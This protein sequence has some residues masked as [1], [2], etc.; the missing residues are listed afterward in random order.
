M[1]IFF[2]FALGLSGVGTFDQSNT[3]LPSVLFANR[4]ENH[5]VPFSSVLQ[6]D[7]CIPP[8]SKCCFYKST[9]MSCIVTICANYKIIRKEINNL[10]PKLNGLFIIKNDAGWMKFFTRSCGGLPGQICN[11]WTNKCWHRTVTWANCINWDYPQPES[12][13]WSRVNPYRCEKYA[14]A[15]SGM[16]SGI[17]NRLD[18]RKAYPSPSDVLSTFAGD[19]VGIAR[20]TERTLGL[21]KRGDYQNNTGKRQDRAS[22]ADPVGKPCGIRCF[23]RRD[24]GAPLSAQ[25]G[26]IV[27]F[28]LITAFGIYVGIGRII[29]LRSGGLRYLFLGLGAFGLFMLWA[30]PN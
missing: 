21:T 24:G 29:R 4:L 17:C 6:G 1:S 10:F 23:F 5:F 14:I 25:I 19:L 22:S 18:I 7:F 26:G 27:I 28:S 12:W 9:P 8:N 11:I 30:S 20:L 2:A 16:F 15:Y 3:L 13:G